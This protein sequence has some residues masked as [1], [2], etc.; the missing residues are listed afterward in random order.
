VSTPDRRAAWCRGV[1]RVYRSAGDEGVYALRAVNCDIEMA[2]LTAVVGPSGSGKTTLLR[3][4]AGLDRPTIGTVVIDGTDIAGLSPR[5]RRR[6]RR[7]SLGFLFAKPNDN[8]LTYLT[9]AEHVRL[10]ARLRGSDADAHRLLDVVGLDQRADHRP[11]ELSGGEQQRLALAA[12]VAGD[13]R[14]VVV[15]EPTAELDRASAAQ[16]VAALRAFVERGLSMVV[17]S[18]D[19][20]VADAADRL[21]RLHDGVVAP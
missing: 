3:I 8:L 11:S 14:L 21:V 1:D 20:I 7:R 17:A 10:A 4:L 13:P 2:R 18:H 16:L 5:A 9:A 15:D 12:A 19:H 6:L